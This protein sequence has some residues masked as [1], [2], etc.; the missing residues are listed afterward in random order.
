MLSRMQLGIIGYGRLGRKVARIGAALG[1]SVD[2]HDPYVA[3]GADSLL[4][5]AAKSDVLTLHAPLTEETRNVVSRRVLASLPRGAVVIN[6]SRGEM[7][8]V[9]AL[10]D[11]IESGHLWGA[12]LDAVA[13]E[14]D[15]DFAARF[16][17]SRLAEYARRSD[18]LI[19]TPHIGGSTIDA[20]RE[21]ER[22]VIDKACAALACQ[23]PA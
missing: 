5:L 20:W 14:Y 19:L 10:I 15:P 18:R 22:K 17:S 2:Y 12:G 11:L 13:G 4:A 23:E 7:L 8:D 1:R 16:A 3:G 9:D 21:T 6:T